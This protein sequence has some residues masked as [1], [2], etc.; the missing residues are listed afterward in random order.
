MSSHSY[1]GDVSRETEDVLYAQTTGLQLATGN[2]R[3]GHPGT[4]N[5]Q[6]GQFCNFIHSCFH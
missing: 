2:G 3:L 5:L 1:K 6:T 4:E